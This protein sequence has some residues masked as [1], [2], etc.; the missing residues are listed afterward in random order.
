MHQGG[1]EH[2]HA[3]ESGD[4]KP[5]G[6]DCFHYV[7]SSKGRVQNVPVGLRN[8]HDDSPF[9][10]DTGSVQSQC[11]H[12]VFP[13]V[14]ISALARQLGAFWRLVI[15]PAT[16]NV[17]CGFRLSLWCQFVRGV[18]QRCLFLLLGL[19]RCYHTIP[20][21]EGNQCGEKFVKCSGIFAAY[22]NITR[23]DFS[24]Y[25]GLAKQNFVEI[26]AGW[27]DVYFAS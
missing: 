4:Q 16:A 9:E 21:I 26:L 1:S 18:P 24:F 17:R 23:H 13:S 19:N 10:K 15:V 22:F 8:T 14:V 12:S 7:D 2:R 6:V 11:L 5:A 20:A 25:L 3:D 27:R